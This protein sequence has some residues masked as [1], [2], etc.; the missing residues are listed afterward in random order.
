M[1]KLSL[2]TRIT[3]LPVITAIAMTLIFLY[4]V[5]YTKNLL[6]DEKKTR[7]LN[8]V[9]TAASL[10]V[11]YKTLAEK[12]ILDGDQAK[13]Q[14]M[15]A[16]NRLRYAGDQYF[17]I[18][19]FQ[20]RMIMH[21]YKPKLNGADLSQSKDPTGKKLFVEMA[22][23]CRA[24]GKGFVDYQWPKPGAEE[25]M[26]KISYVR[27]IPDWDWIVGSGIYVD[28]VNAEI[29]N[30]IVRIGGV[31]LLVFL[32]VLLWGLRGS[33]RI[34]RT[35]KQAVSILDSGS[36][37]VSAASAELTSASQNLA[38]MSSE[39]SSSVGQTVSLLKEIHSAAQ[40]T[41][42][43]TQGQEKLMN[44]NI[45]KSGK[46]VDVL[47]E[48]ATQI[49]KVEEDGGKMGA[50][51]NNIS[52]I[53]FQTN[54]LA[55]NAAVEAARAGEAGAGFAVVADEVKN[56]A[57][58]AAESANSTQELLEHTITRIKTSAASLKAMNQD[59]E[60]IVETATVLG[61]KTLSITRGSNEQVKSIAQINMAMVELEKMIQHMAANSE[62]SAASA[63]ELAA[64]SKT[65]Y[66]VVENL[67]A[68][69]YGGNGVQ[70]KPVGPAAGERQKPKGRG[71]ALKLLSNG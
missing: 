11:H 19:D 1:R 33:K 71:L 31:V 47:V 20:P 41:A 60:G 32:A 66:S 3:M 22:E 64:Q 15:A 21:P 43:I 7:V 16:V 12:G 63:E 10:I 58:R 24:H 69:V 34:A 65:M 55:L 53:A 40:A 46:T 59:F 26:P 48:L 27:A 39:Q 29:N 2:A 50:V 9:E 6:M 14:A 62:E 5:P 23:V 70:A 52:E 49:S 18:N 42:D 51:I 61:Q 25:P 45:R 8:L 38:Q 68:L 30:Y 37:Q 36:Q 56:L 4:V 17:W 44:E 28:D 67:N 54:L 57:T 35:L 13:S